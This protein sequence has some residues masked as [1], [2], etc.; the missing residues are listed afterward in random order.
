MFNA[1]VT[2]WFILVGSLSDARCSILTVHLCECTGPDLSFG[3]VSVASV[4]EKIHES[5][6]L[7]R[8]NCNIFLPA[9]RHSF[10]ALGAVSQPRCAANQPVVLTHFPASSVTLRVLE[11][12][13]FSHDSHLFLPGL[14][15]IVTDS[16]MVLEA[17]WPHFNIS[18]CHDNTSNMPQDEIYTG[19]G[20]CS[21]ISVHEHNCCRL[22]S[23][24][25]HVHFSSHDELWTVR[26]RVNS[27]GQHI[28]SHRRRGKPM[29]HTHSLDFGCDIG[30][31]ANSSTPL[32]IHSA[33]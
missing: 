20:R 12:H 15:V 33:G 2:Y 17:G 16:P 8:K 7:M 25:W 6:M 24:T 13:S 14:R 22:R 5:V 9:H 29:L 26:E 28:S 10:I 4:Q 19:Q 27:W 18:L 32:Q 1:W 23:L 21:H 31:C 30:L 3:R 11:T